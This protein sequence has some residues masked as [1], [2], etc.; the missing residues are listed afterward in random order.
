MKA[1][2]AEYTVFHDPA[3]APEGAAMRDLLVDSFTRCGYDVIQPEDGRDFGTELA[4]LAPGCDVGLVVAPDHL[5]P[6]FI[7]SIEPYTR[8]LGCSSTSAAVCANKKMTAR[9]LRSRGID[10][11]DERRS[12]IR[13]I[14]PIRGCGSQSV[15]LCDEEPSEG[16]FAQEFLEGDHISVSLIGSR[17]VGDTCLSYTGR[18]PLILAVNRQFI[19]I[20]DDGFL[21]Y[22]GGQTPIHHPREDD[23]LDVAMEVMKTLALQGYAGID[24]VVGDDRITVVDVNPRPTTSLVGIAACM[25]EEIAELLVDL[26]YGKGPESVHLSGAVKFDTHGKVEEI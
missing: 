20:D 1:L 8:H 26:S 18:E 14:K 7:R 24:M 11:P 10:V 9:I 13:I 5:L 6:D 22:T 15:R 3:L 4:A 2:I 19:T 17:I 21:R 25:K 23:I 12:G 16:E